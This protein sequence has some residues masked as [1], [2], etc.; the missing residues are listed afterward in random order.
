MRIHTTFLG[1]DD[2][3][4]AARYA[5]GKGDGMVSIDSASMHGSRSHDH[6]FN[7]LLEG[8]GTVNKRRR[9]FGTSKTADRLDR[10]YACTYDQWGH[11]LA[12]LFAIDPDI[13]IPGVYKNAADFHAVTKNAYK[14]ASN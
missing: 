12:A 8:D 2:L 3:Y 6:A 1:S 13:H 10:P 4:V 14:I 5:S 7:V 11:F 9:N